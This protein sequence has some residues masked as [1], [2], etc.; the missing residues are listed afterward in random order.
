MSHARMKDIHSG[1][2]DFSQRPGRFCGIAEEF[3]DEAHNNLS[4][5]K[6]LRH[7][8]SREII[9]S[10]YVRIKR[11]HEPQAVKSERPQEYREH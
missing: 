9:A 5:F 1:N 7:K 2:H 11:L 3:F 10:S 4:P 6:V 8:L